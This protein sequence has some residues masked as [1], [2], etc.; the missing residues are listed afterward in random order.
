MLRPGS[1][2]IRHVCWLR[3][4]SCLQWMAHWNARIR[5]QLNVRASKN[6]SEVCDDQSICHNGNSHVFWTHR[7]HQSTLKT[8]IKHFL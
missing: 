3:E 2:L 1:V 8:N 4:Q 6:N 7:R 5:A